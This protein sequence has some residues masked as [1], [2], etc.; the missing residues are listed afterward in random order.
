MAAARSGGGGGGGAG[1]R[2]A[3]PRGAAGRPPGAGAAALVAE[4]V[5]TCC[6]GPPIDPG[7]L[8]AAPD[9]YA[10]RDAGTARPSAAD[11]AGGGPGPVPDALALDV[12]A[13]EEAA[14]LLDAVAADEQRRGADSAGQPAAPF[15][16]GAA[17]ADLAA[18]TG[19]P[20]APAPHLALTDGGEVALATAIARA[21]ARYGTP[22]RDGRVIPTW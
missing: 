5:E 22:L 12:L 15:P 17:L 9:A 10:A 7:L 8:A 18:G 4:L 13:G 11:A 19:I 20:L 2:G 3:P 21:E 14:D 16:L 6:A 1:R